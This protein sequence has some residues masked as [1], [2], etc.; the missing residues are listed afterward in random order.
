MIW[1]DWLLSFWG[2]YTRCLDDDFDKEVVIELRDFEN[3]WEVGLSIYFK[4]GDTKDMTISRQFLDGTSLD[5]AKQ[6]AT[7]WAEEVIEKL[8]CLVGIH[9]N[10]NLIKWLAETVIAYSDLHYDCCAMSPEDCKEAM[11]MKFPVIQTIDLQ[12]KLRDLSKEVYDSKAAMRELVEL[13]NG[14]FEGKTQEVPDEV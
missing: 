3:T 8:N 11:I 2:C 12:N 14:V 9:K 5:D 4:S 13:Y 7:R 1:K 10:T 6:E